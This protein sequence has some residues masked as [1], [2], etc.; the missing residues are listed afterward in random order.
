MNY[1]WFSLATVCV[2][3]LVYRFIIWDDKQLQH[4]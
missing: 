4:R 2:Y 3:Y 1:F